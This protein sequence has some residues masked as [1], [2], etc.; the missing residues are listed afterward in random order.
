VH[1][2]AGAWPSPAAGPFK[3]WGRCLPEHS[4]AVSLLD[5]LLDH[6]DLVATNGESYR[7]KEARTR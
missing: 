4:T 7:S 1:D 6:N 3:E 2:D 5:R